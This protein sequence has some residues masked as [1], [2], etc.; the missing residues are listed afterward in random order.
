[1]GL[2]EK[3]AMQEALTTPAKSAKM[4]ALPSP[5]RFQSILTTPM[6]TSLAVVVV[7]RAALS[8]EQ[9]IFLLAVEAVAVDVVTLRELREF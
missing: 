4:E 5:R 8:V 9:P 7:A 1:M 2:V 6:A 3:A